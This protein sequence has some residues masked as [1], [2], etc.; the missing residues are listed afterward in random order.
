MLNKGATYQMADD[1]Q[2]GGRCYQTFSPTFSQ[3]LVSVMT[4]HINLL[5][6]DHSEMASYEGRFASGILAIF[7]KALIN[8][9]INLEFNHID[10]I[11]KLRAWSG[12]LGLHRPFSQKN[13]D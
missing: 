8:A 3:L 9:N 7:A 12:F 1:S 5:P 11:S 13:R 2:T 6:V 4:S 10:F